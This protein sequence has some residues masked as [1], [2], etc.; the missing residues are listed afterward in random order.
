MSMHKP[1]EIWIEQCEAAETIR[2]RYGLQAAFD[3][4]VGEKLLNFAFAAEQHPA[5]ARALPQFVS[6]VREMFTPG[7][8]LA[9]LERIEHQRKQQEIEMAE[10]DDPFADNPA[11]AAAQF[12]QFATIKELLTVTR[13][14]TS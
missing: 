3:Y 5:F 1:H 14:G 9:H 11:T 8:I 13:L 12:R 4:V 10:D 2:Q 6:R 7:Q